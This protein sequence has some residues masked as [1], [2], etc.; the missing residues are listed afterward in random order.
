MAHVGMSSTRSFVLQVRDGEGLAED[1][2]TI[3]KRSYYDTFDEAEAS[4]Q[5]RL[6]RG[7]V[8]RIEY[9]YV[10]DRDEVAD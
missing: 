10:V 2:F 3:P 8:D 5:R 4:A 1:M 7:D 6:N 9:S